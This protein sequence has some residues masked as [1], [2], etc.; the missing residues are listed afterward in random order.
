MPGVLVNKVGAGDFKISIKG[1]DVLGIPR[2]TNQYNSQP[3][4]GS[5]TGIPAPDPVPVLEGWFLSGTEYTLEVVP[6]GQARFLRW[7]GDCDSGGGSSATCTMILGP[8]DKQ[9][10]AF[11][12][13][14]NCGTTPEG[15]IIAADGT[16][17]GSP[18]TKVTP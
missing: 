11:F 8:D 15:N 14:W 4:S 18:C 12:E 17:P 6:A 3:P 2:F 7:V 10:T 1:P 13:Y 5:S 9:V 16:A